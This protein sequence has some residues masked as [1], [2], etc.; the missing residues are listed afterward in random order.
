METIARADFRASL[1]ARDERLAISRPRLCVDLPVCSQSYKWGRRS[2]TSPRITI[3]IPTNFASFPAKNTTTP[4]IIKMN[5]LKLKKNDMIG[6]A[7]M[8]LGKGASWY[9]P[10]LPRLRAKSPR[11]NE[12]IADKMPVILI[13]SIDPP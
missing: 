1:L 4:R 2:S 12:L 10:A 9:G 7:I 5:G 8:E 6:L 3:T 13:S 11:N